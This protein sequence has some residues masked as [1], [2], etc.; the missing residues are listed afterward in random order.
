[1]VIDYLLFFVGLFVCFYSKLDTCVAIKNK[2]G[3]WSELRL[4][5]TVA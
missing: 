3:F 4:N 5:S 1:M 2:N